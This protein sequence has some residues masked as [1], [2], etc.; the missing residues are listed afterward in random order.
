MLLLV[1][2]SASSA[3]ASAAVESGIMPLAAGTP[4]NVAAAT[5]QTI[6]FANPGPQTV[7]TSLVLS[8]TASSGLPVSFASSTAN[9]CTVTGATVTFLTSGSCTITASQSGNSFY[10]AATPV[11]QTFAVSFIPA[12]PV[13][14]SEDL[15]VSQ[16]NW[17]QTFGGNS[18]TINNPAGGSLA[19]NTNGEIVAGTGTAV[20]LF[21]AVTGAETTLGSWNGVGPT[22]VDGGNNIY[23]G[24]YSA[25]APIVRLPYVG[26]LANGGYVPFTVPGATTPTCT[27]TSTVECTIAAAGGVNTAA[28]TFDPAGD[29]FYATAYQGSGANAIYECSVACLAGTGSPVMVYQEPAA[30]TPPSATSG[31]LLIGAIAVDPLGNL[32]F[33]DSST[34]VSQ[35]NSQF[36]SFF[37]NLKELPKTSGGVDSGGVL[38]YALQPATLYSETPSVITPANNEVDA[39]VI[40]PATGTVYFA[41]QGN[42]LFAFPNSGSTIPLANGQPTSLYTV[43]TQGAKALALD[44]KGN[45]YFVASSSVISPAADTVGQIALNSITVPNSPVGVAVSPSSTLNPVTTV[46]NDG[47]CSAAPPPSAT[48]VPT[49][50]SSAT[51]TISV[52]AS[53]T[54]TVSGAAALATTVT[55]TPSVL[56]NDS[57]TLTGTDQLGNTATVTV[58]G[59]G[60]APLTP[61]TITF[62]NPGTQS[63][64]TPLTLT[65]TAT[66]GLP[67]TFT[68]V[69]TGVC[70]VA[71]STATFIAA[72]MCTIDA[73]QG[74][75][76]TYAAAPQVQQ[77]FAVTPAPSFT[78]VPS[79]GT[80]SVTQDATATDT[81]T[82]TPA[83]GFTGS[84]TLTATGLPSGVTVR[85]GSNPATGASSVTFT[86]SSTAMPGTSTVTI[87][88]AS[89]SL[90][91][92]TTIV[93][94][95]NAAPSF[96]LSAGAG[97]V[98]VVAGASVSDSIN[99][100]AANGFTGSVALAATGLPS[101]VTASFSVNPATSTSVLTITA[102]SSAPAGTTTVTLTGTSGTLT[103]STTI[104]L[105]VT[106]LQS[107]TLAPTVAAVSISPGGTAT[108][109]IK[110]IAANGFTGSVSLAASGLPSGVTASFAP[111]PAT[112]S[113]VITLTATSA[114]APGTATVT[115][116]GTSG[117]LTA[118]TALSVSVSAP[119][120]ITVT[121][122]SAS[123]TLNPGA[124]GT[125]VITVAGTNGFSGSVVL[126]AAI[127]AGPQGAQDSPTLNF[128]STSPVIV[129]PAAS[130]AATLSITTTAA[131][132]SALRYPSRGGSPLALAGGAAMA[133]L[134][135]LMLP[136]KRR[137][138]PVALA[139]AFVL[140]ATG[141][142]AGC[143]SG[144]SGGGGGGGSTGT[145]AGNYT[146]TI[147][148][149]SGSIVQTTPVTV[150]VE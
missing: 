31:Q 110:V 40:N 111:A 123:V 56:G 128:G 83:D 38:G 103:A 5:T 69:T 42:G 132:T 100:N 48:V 6:A 59:V 133:G 24:N 1:V 141:A 68:S 86:A 138:L 49:G 20:V 92:S 114:A 84:V 43:S 62:S 15:I 147:A 90:S 116:T 139:L 45:F 35:A 93:L 16:V 91:A 4:P 36:T 12:V 39:L 101:G 74:G 10:A 8:A 34:Y 140:Y 78:L 23:L 94:T 65:A 142:L 108:D 122:A 106:G 18:L 37:S 135:F 81:V 52:S 19:V 11:S 137:R 22:A 75:N 17:L 136:F 27:S 134:L 2:L 25:G 50:N 28:L 58:S 76:T 29:L 89:G 119:A 85:F 66:S 77:S 118:S 131:T 148:A 60:L 97:S 127:T 124:G 14:A 96:T 7:G 95:V 67:V 30:T 33:T 129:T 61:Q 104:S 117:T 9:V 46:L 143:G 55:F 57:A 47:S 125:D 71:G 102:S 79:A 109:T 3:R 115:I 144:G 150:I 145:T 26:G 87:T 113:S 107:F 70:T 146:V 44:S 82:V 88:G 99:I 120:S 121:P 13:P 149:T 73:S 32:F 126:S 98:S 80:L 64:G 63:E 54:S 41:D 112:S 72:G 51:A 130:G 21:N 53:C 105:T